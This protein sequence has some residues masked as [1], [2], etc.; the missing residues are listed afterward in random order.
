MI[1]FQI[2]ERTRKVDAGGDLSNA[3]ISEPMVGYAIHRKLG[4]MVIHGAIRDTAVLRAAALP[5]Y[6][7]GVTH[8]GPYKDG[9]GEINVPVA[10]AGM[11][12]HP[13]DLI[14]GDDDGVLCIPFADVGAVYVA[15]CRKMQEEARTIA[16][17]ES[18]RQDT[19]WD[20]AR[21]RGLGCAV[22]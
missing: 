8:R 21:L 1:G 19:S 6:A 17:I 7:A 13:G 9:P 10:I 22:P 4:G 2:R 11:V 20:D 5:V 3:L 12:V 15:V 14:V 18:G 16:N